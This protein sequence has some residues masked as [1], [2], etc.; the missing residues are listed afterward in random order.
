[1]RPGF[2]LGVRL[3]IS[4]HLGPLSPSA[5]IRESVI[6]TQTVPQEWCADRCFKAILMGEMASL[7]LSWTLEILYNN[8]LETVPHMEL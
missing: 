6:R 1:V 8:R 3:D 7:R 4:Y 2:H 5:K